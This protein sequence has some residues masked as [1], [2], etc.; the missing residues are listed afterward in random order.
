MA[1]VIRAAAL[2]QAERAPA[3]REA[4]AVIGRAN[5]AD[6]DAVLPLL[7]YGRSWLDAS[8]PPPAI[9][10]DGLLR[11]VERVPASPGPRLLLGRVLA[12]R[13]QAAA[14][15]TMLRPIVLGP[16]VSPERPQAEAL[17]ATLPAN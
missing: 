10:A 14:A 9:A 2:P 6:T 1:Q 7:A 15:R 16:Y 4:R 3:L 12:T 17:T 11:V 5:R 8:V 13:G